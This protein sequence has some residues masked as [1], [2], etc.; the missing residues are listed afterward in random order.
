MPLEE[1]VVGTIVGADSP[2]VG[3]W[4]DEG[5]DSFNSSG[6]RFL[7]VLGSVILAKILGL[8]FISGAE[9]VPLVLGAGDGVY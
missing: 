1:S 7:P 8:D 3:S 2:A 9:A 6:V 4:L 5:L